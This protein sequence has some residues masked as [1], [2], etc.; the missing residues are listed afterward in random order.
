M[1]NAPYELIAVAH[2]ADLDML[3]AARCLQLLNP[4]AHILHPVRL[5]QNAWEAVRR[6]D[7]FKTIKIS[8]VDFSNIRCVHMIGINQSRHNIELVEAVGRY[9][10]EAFVY[11]ER[12]PRLPFSYIIKQ[13]HNL[14]LTAA[15][16]N[17]LTSEGVDLSNDDLQLFN[18]AVCEKTWLG[19]SSKCR[20]EDLQALSFL[21]KHNFSSFKTSNAIS[22]GFREGQAAAYHLM[23]K[24]M[25][26]IQPGYWPIS[27]TAIKLSSAIQDMEPVIDAVWSDIAASSALIMVTYQNFSRVWARSS[28][29]QIDFLE[30]FHDFRPSRQ[31][32]WIY[33][34]FSGNG[35]EQNR[36]RL[37]QHLESNLKSD[38]TAG[39]IMSASPR[40]VD[41]GM[42]V[43]QA[44]DEML[45]FNIMSLIVIKSSQFAGI[46]TRRDLDRALQMNLP[47]S[48]IEPWVPTEMPV[49]SP[50]T[51]VRALKNLMIRYNLTRLPVIEHGKVKG[52]ITTHELLRAIPD[53]LPL[54]HDFLPLAEKI[55]MPDP[56]QI[57]EILKRVFSLRIFHILNKISRFSG[58]LGIATFAV[59]GF[60]R[61]LL[62]ERQNFDLDVVVIGDAM[63]FAADFS[64]ELNC[65]FKVFDR[66]HT[67][68]I[69]LEDLKVDF[70]SARIEHYATP[71]ALPQIE[72]SGLSNDLYRR[73]FT[74]NALALALTPE[75]FLQL[76]DFFGGFNDLINRKIKILHSF[77]F[78]EDPTRLFRA[79]RFAGRFNFSLEKD[80]RRA[81][82]LAVSREAIDRLSTKRIATEISRC[83][84]EDRPQQVISDFFE[85]G[86]MKF[87]SPELIDASILP[88]RFKLIRSL[89]K[90]FKPMPEEIDSEAI[91]WAGLLSA[92][93]LDC[94]EKL[95]DVTG[96]PHN[97]RVKIL[98]A[99]NSMSAIPGQ[100]NHISENDHQGLYDLLS[101]LYPEALISTVAFAVNKQNARKIL[102]YIINLRQ[103]RC[104]ITGKDLMA[105][106]IKP[107]PHI[108]TIFN[109]II[110]LKLN[111]QSLSR[112]EELKIAAEFYSNL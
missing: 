92:L 7:W 101:G 48:E 35:H 5:K 103:I 33:F 2:N 85:A 56:E 10:T 47:D 22:L 9:N 40:C 112:E 50:S 3:G 31:R 72:Y 77:S 26:D 37:I 8:D 60:V 80:T 96:T 74:I 27:F 71:G 73:D 102:Y 63:K 17:R 89:V 55:Q 81:F 11:T 84:N 68:R 97:R 51:P 76:K 58:K 24:S 67:A 14:S 110:S 1:K 59:G 65:D 98:Q 6:L 86:L 90:R 54:P 88:G 61:D 57:E 28:V 25:E 29:S 30:V 108:R 44:L 95:L 13:Q 23:L 99:L 41:S 62:L 32:N 15:L 39:D 79:L 34:S 100:L 94:A 38:L 104:L 75:N 45:K 70:S 93:N 42:S 4:Q 19:L 52:I 106:G 91:Y 16:M 107:G 69:Y 21:R 18:L 64:K 111:G 109:N 105:A 78:L 66:F 87:L 36:I 20:N 53:Y 83:F 12:Q 43:K 46:V 49:V 82:E